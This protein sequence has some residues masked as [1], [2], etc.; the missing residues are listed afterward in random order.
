MIAPYASAMALMVAP[1]EACENLQR[2]AVEGRAGTF[3]FYEAVDYTPRRLPPLKAST[4]IRS[5]MVHHQ[6]MTLLALDN[7]L[8]DYPMQRRFMGCPLLRAAD[9]L[10]QERMPKTCLLYTSP[11]PRD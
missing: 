1:V 8:H 7:L 10:L 6:G 9:L 2:L 3:G 11:S 4:T 5:F